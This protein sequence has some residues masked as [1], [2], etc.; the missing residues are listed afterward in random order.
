[1]ITMTSKDNIQ[2]LGHDLIEIERIQQVLDR[3]KERFIERILTP[4]EQSEYRK[5]AHPITYLAGR[6]AAKEAVAKAL[7]CGIG[8][9]L[10]WQEIEILSDNLGKPQV[11]LS[12]ENIHFFVS[13]SHTRFYASAVVIATRS[14]SHK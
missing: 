8:K 7:G 3:H 13:I 12:K 6:F 14:Q 10:S 1:M 9:E 11:F 2:G 4:N 5:R